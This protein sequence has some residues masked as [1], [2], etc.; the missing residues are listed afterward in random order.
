MA[1]PGLLPWGPP[2]IDFILHIDKHLAELVANHGF[3]AYLILGGILFGETGLLV[4]PFLPGDTLLFGCGLLA[5]PPA[6][7]GQP[8]MSL[9]ILLTVLPVAA[10][11]G[12]S[13]NYWIGR[14]FRRMALA[15]KRIP[16]M[17]PEMIDRAHGFF[18][19]YGPW[20]VVLGRWV[21]LVRT[22]VPFTAGVSTMTYRRFVIYSTLGNFLWVGAFVLL[23]FKLGKFKWV[24]EN[25]GLVFIGLIVCVVVSLAFKLTAGMFKGKAK[26]G[27]KHPGNLPDRVEP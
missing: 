11:M 23:G 9:A 7:G 12:D 13:A 3:G 10:I 8:I 26:A 20:A 22:V 21:P 5:A 17:S 18:E 16:F 25:I 2:M 1:P 14:G 6:D 4:L 27:G 19:R 15:R 24:Q